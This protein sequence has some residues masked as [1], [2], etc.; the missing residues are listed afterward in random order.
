MPKYRVK[1]KIIAS[2]SYETIE[3]F[4]T[5]GQAEEASINRWREKISSDFQV[6]KFD[7]AQTEA[8]Q[9]SWECENCNREITYEEWARGDSWCAECAVK[10][11]ANRASI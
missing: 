9:I 1:T 8:E 10:E 11:E 2:E 6:D 7:E 3:D 5:E 4:P